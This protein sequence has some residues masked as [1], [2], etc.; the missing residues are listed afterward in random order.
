MA[1]CSS[2]TARA[3]LLPGVIGGICL[4]LGLFALQLLPV[5]YAGLGLIA[6]GVGLMVAEHFVPGFG[7]SASA[8]LRPSWSAR[9]C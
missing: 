1:C 3:L 5:N 9:S 8:A 6:L 2:S 4:L 7:S